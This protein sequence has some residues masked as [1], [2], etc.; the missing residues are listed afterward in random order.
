VIGRRLLLGGAALPLFAIV[1]RRAAA[2]ASGNLALLVGA[3][4]GSPE[5]HAARAFAPFLARHLPGTAIA[6][7]NLPGGDG[8][9]A[10]HALLD[11]PPNGLTVLWGVTP[12]LPAQ[13][14]AGDEGALLDRIAF[15]AAVRREPVAFVSP[16]LSKL[17]TTRDLL[18]AADARGSALPL[19]TP[20]AGSP[21][22]LAVLQL[23]ALSQTPLAVVAFPSAFAARQA[24]RAGT[25]CAAALALSDT[26]D[27][28]RDGRL[29]GLGITASSRADVFP[30]IA[31][32]A[33]A[34]LGL[35]MAILR[36]LATR[37]D[38]SEAMARRLL[39]AL[40]GVAADP[41]F[42][43]E[44]DANGFQVAW[45]E[46]TAWS[47]AARSARDDLSA[48]WP[49]GARRTLEAASQPG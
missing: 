35:S 46:G 40:G 27:D 2:S 49:V 17:A 13:C 12:T 25:A 48:L 18:R 26:I 21:P 4:A 39:D 47:T 45:I 36:G 15:L 20:Q 19:A 3:A 28:L 23:Q 9:A 43:A 16:A 34:G 29:V 42:R 44:A 6:I 11:A 10:C 31:P 1:R 41:E 7:A 22:H 8:L 14:L 33:D 24:V 5:D 38:L 30:D 37:T 32:M